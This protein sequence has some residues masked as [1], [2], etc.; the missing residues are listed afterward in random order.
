MHAP[1]S[2]RVQIGGGA[3]LRN[4]KSAQELGVV[5]VFQDPGT[6]R[7]HRRRPTRGWVGRSQLQ[8]VERPDA[9]LK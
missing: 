7:E 1:D 3:Q 9:V 8:P 5:T 4:P 2:G 6:C